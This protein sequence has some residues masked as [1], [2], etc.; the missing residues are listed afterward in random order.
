MN[1]MTAQPSMVTTPWSE[2]RD[3][4]HLLARPVVPICGSRVPQELLSNLRHT[5]TQDAA[6]FSRSGLLYCPVILLMTS[7]KITRLSAV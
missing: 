2:S 7:F 3:I 4:F 5:H 1:H 6:G